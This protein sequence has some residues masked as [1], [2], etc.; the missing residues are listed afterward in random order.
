MVEGTTDVDIFLSKDEDKKV[1]CVELPK[2]E[3]ENSVLVEMRWDQT[4]Q[5]ISAGSMTIWV[6]LFETSGSGMWRNWASDEKAVTKNGD[7]KMGTGKTECGAHFPPAYTPPN[8][9]AYA[10]SNNGPSV[11]MEDILMPEDRLG[12]RLPN[13]E[14]LPD[15]PQ[16]LENSPPHTVIIQRHRNGIFIEGTHVGTI[17]LIMN[18]F[19]RQAELPREL[20]SSNLFNCEVCTHYP[21]D[22]CS[23]YTLIRKQNPK[24][25]DYVVSVDTA[26]GTAGFAIRLRN[27]DDERKRTSDDGHSYVAGCAIMVSFME[28]VCGYKLVKE[29][30]GAGFYFFRWNDAI[31]S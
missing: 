9:Y 20:D 16:M 24:R 25:G 14:S 10:S 4:A 11:V 1:L 31:E 17:G 23:E 8:E 13:M 7:E 26:F 21:G 30:S 6:N 3:D 29:L 27:S 2:H 18:Y 22:H 15:L 5:V 28:N 19:N 12:P